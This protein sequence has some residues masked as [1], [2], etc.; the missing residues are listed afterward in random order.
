MGSKSVNI[1]FKINKYTQFRGLETN[2]R[3]SPTLEN[4]VL[5]SCTPKKIY[6]FS[7][8][9]TI[10]F[11]GLFIQ[12]KRNIWQK[13]RYLQ[14]AEAGPYIKSET[15]QKCCH[16]KRHMPE[17][18]INCWPFYNMGMMFIKGSFIKNKIYSLSKEC[19]SCYW[20][21]DCFFL[22]DTKD[23]IMSYRC[24]YWCFGKNPYYVQLFGE[25]IF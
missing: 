22:R 5:L 25:W 2:P 17:G 9:A 20:T 19:L 16:I 6:L 18:R 12:Q 23:D 13:L 7:G 3:T 4:L 11:S 8:V 15:H 14:V 24:C 21:V 1:H 10:L